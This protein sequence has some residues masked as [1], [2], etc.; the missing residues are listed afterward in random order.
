MLSVCFASSSV[1]AILKWLNISLFLSA[2]VSSVLIILTH[3]KG[4]NVS[5]ISANCPCRRSA[6]IF[7]VVVVIFFPGFLKEW[8]QMN[9][10]IILLF[11]TG[12]QLK[13]H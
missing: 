4:E 7:D 1:F 5:W 2:G 13:K 11:P 6:V 9:L 8:N 12:K 3:K 10:I